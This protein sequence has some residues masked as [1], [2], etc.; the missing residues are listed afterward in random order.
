[1]YE[2]DCADMHPDTIR[3][4]YG[5]AGLVRRRPHQS[6]A[7][8]PPEEESDTDSDSDVG[9]IGDQ[10]AHD[11]EHNIRHEPI[12]VPDG[13]SPFVDAASEHIFLEA[14]ETYK[15]AA[16]IPEGYGVLPEEMHGD[17][18]TYEILRTGKRGGKEMEIPLPEHVWRRRTELWAKGLHLMNHVLYT[19]Q[20][21]E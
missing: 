18:E 13:T 10:I 19:M 21:N 17:Y 9:S 8:H 16:V 3:R 5:V 12:E 2:D 20:E 14:W 4:Y 15:V 7:G 11:Q 6:G 1:M